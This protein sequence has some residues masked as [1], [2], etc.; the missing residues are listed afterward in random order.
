MKKGLMIVITTIMLLLLS[1]CGGT[2]IESETSPSDLGKT[3]TTDDETEKNN[4]QEKTD[5]PMQESNSDIISANGYTVQ[6]VNLHKTKDSNGEPMAAA[7]FLFTNENEEPISFMGAIS[8]IAFQNGIELTKDEMFLENDYDWD[9]YYTEIKDG[10]KISVF[11]PIPLQNE[12]VSVE[13]IVEIMDF[14]NW[15]S[16]ASTTRKFDLD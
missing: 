5:E 8:F 6:I 9:S 1:S 4:E 12:T 14:T 16:E 7:E 11:R 15:T 3:E 13:L 2:N 10:S